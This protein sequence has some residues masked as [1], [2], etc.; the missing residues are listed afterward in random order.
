M[1]FSVIHGKKNDDLH[2]ESKSGNEKVNGL[3]IAVCFGGGML[4][5]S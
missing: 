4:T 1:A 5:D 2:K 3:R